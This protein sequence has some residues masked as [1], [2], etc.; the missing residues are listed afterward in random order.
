MPPTSGLAE[1]GRFDL[2]AGNREVHLARMRLLQM[3]HDLTHILDGGSTSG[4]NRRCNRCDNLL[5]AKLR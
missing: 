2:L 5:L 1:Q 4:V 3:T